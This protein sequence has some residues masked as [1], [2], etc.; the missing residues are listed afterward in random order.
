MKMVGTYLFFGLGM[1]LAAV[2]LA[3]DLAS[4]RPLDP[5]VLDRLQSLLAAH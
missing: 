3:V 1:V 5:L 4:R 2:A